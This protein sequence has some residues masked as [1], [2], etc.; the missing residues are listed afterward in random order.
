M[1]LFQLT[2]YSLSMWEVK[3]GNQLNPDAGTEEETVE[4]CCLL[5]CFQAHI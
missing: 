4:E 3:T 1:S 2:G 5:A